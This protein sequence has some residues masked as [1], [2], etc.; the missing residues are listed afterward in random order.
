MKILAAIKVTKP[1]KLADNSLRWVSRAGCDLVLFTAPFRHR[2]VIDAIW[3]ANYHYYCGLDEDL[4]AFG[5][6]MNFARNNGYD[7]L[8]TV[9]EDLQSWRKDSRFR[10]REILYFAEALG[11]AR[12][13]FSQNP[14]KQIHRWKNGVTME[15]VNG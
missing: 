10:P 5:K 13:Q 3:D 12:K 1:K 4:I 15:R 11:K 8:V 7:L 2:K 6:P 9:P 14:N